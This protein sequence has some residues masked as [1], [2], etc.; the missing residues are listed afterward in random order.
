MSNLMPG[1]KLHCNIDEKA[2]SKAMFICRLFTG[3]SMVYLALGSLFYWR[4]FLVNTNALGFPFAVAVSFVL[5]LAELF[6][7]FFLLLGWYTRLNALF[8]LILGIVCCVVFFAGEYNKVFVALCLLQIG[9]LCPVFL[10]GPGAISL[11]FKRS[12]RRAAQRFFRG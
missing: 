2:F 8:S 1:V 7:G 9:S 10:L 11:D 6:L 3:L 12:Q 5:V 4:E